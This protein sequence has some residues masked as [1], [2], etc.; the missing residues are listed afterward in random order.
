MPTTRRE[1]GLAAD[2]NGNLYA[3]GGYDGVS[4]PPGQLN[5]VEM[6]D[7]TSDSW[8]PKASLPV[9]RLSM[10]FAFSSATGKFYSVGGGTKAPTMMSMNMIVQTTPGHRR[11]LCSPTGLPLA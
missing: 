1:I 8:T 5:T 2:S 3:V 11:A 7:P 4:D 6:Y 10:G 9:H